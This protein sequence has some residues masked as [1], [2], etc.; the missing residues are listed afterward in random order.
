MKVLLSWMRS[1]VCRRK[2]G[3]ERRWLTPTELTR[4]TFSLGTK[5]IYIDSS[6]PQFPLSHR[7]IHINII[8][9]NTV[10]FV[11][12]IHKLVCGQQQVQS[13][14]C[15]PRRGC[16]SAG[17]NK[18]LALPVCLHRKLRQN[19][20]CENFLCKQIDKGTFSAPHQTCTLLKL[21]KTRG[22]RVFEQTPKRA[23]LLQSGAGRGGG[24]WHSGQKGECLK[25]LGLSENEI[26]FYT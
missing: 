20:N 21:A 23:P 17:A 14:R 2:G 9:V 6:D 22:R 24:A 19:S 13:N 4:L 26:F 8:S 7:M 11:C 16:K 12:N 18:K 3:R 10:H 1:F 5:N 15:W 25:S